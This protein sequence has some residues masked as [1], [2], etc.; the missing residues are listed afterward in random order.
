MSLSTKNIKGGE[1]A[2]MLKNIIPGQH[3]VKIN[4]IELKRFSFMDA[5]QGYYLNMNVETEPIEGFEGFLKDYNDESKGRYDG[6]IGVVKMNRYYYKDGATKSGVEISRDEEILKAIKRL[7][8]ATGCTGWFDDVDGKYNTIE[9]FV[10]GFNATAPFKDQY[11]K[12]TVAGRE[13][14]KQSGYIGYDLFLAK[15]TKGKLNIEA[16]DAKISKLVPFN[17]DEHWTK[18]VAEEVSNFGDND[19]PAGSPDLSG[20]PDFEL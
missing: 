13:Y 1:S 10:E 16:A 9:E 3:K 14:Q 17:E 5:D 7:C 15:N 2:G 6:Q 18:F 12:M 4:S 11:V 19:I 20:A 8:A